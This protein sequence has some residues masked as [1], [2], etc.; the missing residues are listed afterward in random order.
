MT[1]VANKRSARYSGARSGTAKHRAGQ[2]TVTKILQ[3]AR[4]L[5]TERGHSDFSMRNVADAAGVHLA[6]VQYYFPRRD[7]L[8]QALLIDTG[9]RYRAL[10]EQALHGVADDPIE[11]LRDRIKGENKITVN[12]TNNKVDLTVLKKIKGVNSVSLSDEGIIILSDSDID[13]RPEIF[14]AVVDA[15]WVI[16]EMKKEDINV[17]HVFQKLTKEDTYV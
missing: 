17:E 4:T 3:A 16:L 2:A 1:R 9:D 10:Y 14:K 11:R 15:G 12:L 7:D 6:N 5:L 13:I 8:V